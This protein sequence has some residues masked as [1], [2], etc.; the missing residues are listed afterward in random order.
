MAG[1]TANPDITGGLANLA[2]QTFDFI[3]SPYT[4]TANLNAI[5]VF[6]NDANGRWSWEQMLYGGCF[7]AYRGTLGEL[8]A[9]GTARN[10]QHMR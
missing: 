5:E 2:D 7:S 4:D 8:T 3:V 1:G 6:L 9:F 10:D